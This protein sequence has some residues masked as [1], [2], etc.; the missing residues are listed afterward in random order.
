MVQNP[1]RRFRRIVPL[2]VSLAMLAGC[3][4]V[5]PVTGGTEG[6]LAFGEQ[7]L[8]DIQVSVHE[9]DGTKF[10]CIGFG[11]TDRDG[12]FTLVTNGAKG[13]LWLSRG[14]YCFTLESAGAPVQI[15]AEYSQPETSPLKVSW[16]GGDDELELKVAT[17]LRLP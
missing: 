5:R 14:E 9:R 6:T 11:V 13:P 7:L 1:C 10:T 8:S 2:L 15:P 3:G 12:V 17:A 4:G 16:S